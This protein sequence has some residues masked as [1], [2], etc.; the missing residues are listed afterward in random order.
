MEKTPPSGE[1]RQCRLALLPS[2]DFSSHKKE[3]TQ[4]KQKL[5]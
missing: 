5:N 1:G 4:D 3:E 2:Q